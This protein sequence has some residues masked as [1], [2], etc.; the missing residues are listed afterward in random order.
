MNI[1][2]IAGNFSAGYQNCILRV[3]KNYEGNNPNEICFLN[4]FFDLT[5]KYFQVIGDTF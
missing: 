2:I 4:S 5:G 1:G 3:K